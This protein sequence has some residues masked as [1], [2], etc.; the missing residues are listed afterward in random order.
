MS[1]GM[2][3]CHDFAELSTEHIYVLNLDYLDIKPSI[4]LDP[5]LEYLPRIPVDDNSMHESFVRVA[6]AK[7][8]LTLKSTLRS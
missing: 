2:S 8:F 3:D 5:C 6:P 1:T 4:S 7:P